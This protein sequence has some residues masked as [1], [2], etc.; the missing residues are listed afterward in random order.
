MD[1]YYSDS[2]PALIHCKFCGEDYAATYKYCP[3]CNTAPNGKK[4]GPSARDEQEARR[5]RRGAHQYP[6]RRLRRSPQPAGGS[7]HCGCGGA[8]R[9][10]YC[11]SRF[12]GQIRFE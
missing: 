6:R 5:R 2:Q 10:G 8:G 12:A 11:G 3:F 4:M 1:D 7:G 9:C